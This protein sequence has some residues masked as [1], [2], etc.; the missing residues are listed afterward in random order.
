MSSD[1][2]YFDHFVDDW[3][4][5]KGKLFSLHTITPLRFDYFAGMARQELGGL[6]GKRVLDVGCGGGLLSERFALEGSL[7]TGIDLSPKAI[8][9]AKRHREE[10][11]GACLSINYRLI[12]VKTL[13]EENP[14]PFDCIVCSEVLEHVDCPSGFV[15][16]M[17]SM[18]KTSGLFFF[19]TINRTVKARF[20]ALFL[21]EDVLGILPQGTHESKRFIKPSELSGYMLKAGVRVAD[22]KGMGLDPLRM[23]FKITRDTSIN[24]IGYG[25][26]G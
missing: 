8:E 22:V 11:G 6:K 7:V 16:E 5:P 14:E 9:S 25:I 4:N 24:Y 18:L 1:Q 20:F 15:L 3:W 26:K 19:S 17:C 10:S 2:K 21:V 23:G 13:L 12:S